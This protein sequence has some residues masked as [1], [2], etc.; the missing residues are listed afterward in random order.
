LTEVMDHPKISA[1]FDFDVSG[2]VT[3]VLD[4]VNGEKLIYAEPILPEIS[5]ERALFYAKP[6]IE[7]LGSSLNV[8]V[9]DPYVKDRRSARSKGGSRRSQ[10]VRS[11][12]RKRRR[13]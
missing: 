7:S 13:E 10:S 9:K 3:D 2:D 4:V 12:S 6:V 1:M 5:D 11:E 8:L